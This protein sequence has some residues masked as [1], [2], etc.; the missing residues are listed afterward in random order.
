MFFKIF[1]F[2]YHTMSMIQT[3][4]LS[5][6]SRNHN[7]SESDISK[8]IFK[9]GSVICEDSALQQVLCNLKQWLH[10]SLYPLL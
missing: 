2:K 10:T 7:S 8:L 3:A 9:C 6:A 4:N 5:V 1:F